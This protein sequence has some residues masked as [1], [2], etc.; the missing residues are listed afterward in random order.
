LGKSN[1]PR[2]NGRRLIPLLP[3]SWNQGLDDSDATSS[4]PPGPDL[5]DH[6]RIL[7]PLRSTNIIAA[8]IAEQTSAVAD[9]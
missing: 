1:S 2:E 9:V 4:V 5:P 7:Q 8:E 6:S 3:P